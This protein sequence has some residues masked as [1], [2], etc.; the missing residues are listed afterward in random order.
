MGKKIKY[1]LNP[2]IFYNRLSRDELKSYIE[3]HEY[4]AYFVADGNFVMDTVAHL[5]LLEENYADG[6]HVRVTID[7]LNHM[8]DK[9]C[10]KIDIYTTDDTRLATLFYKPSEFIYEYTDL[11]I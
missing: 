6:I 8:R 1:T 11:I 3:N 4:R 2:S 10:D 9:D 7:N 5:E